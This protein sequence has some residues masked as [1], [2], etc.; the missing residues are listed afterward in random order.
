M[1]FQ[2]PHCANRLSIPDQY[3]G[4]LMKCPICSK[5][6]QAPNLVPNA[7]ASP[8]PP[9]APAPA[10]EGYK[11]APEPPKPAPPPPPP[12]PAATSPVSKSAAPPPPPPTGPTDYTGGF[13]GTLDPKI[14]PWIAPAC[15][16]LVLGLLFFPWVGQYWGSY[17]VNVQTGWGAAFGF[18]TPDETW[19]KIVN[20]DRE[21]DYAGVNVLVIFFIL[22]LLPAIL[23]AIVSAVLPLLHISLPPQVEQLKTW[24]WA[25]VAGVALLAFLLLSLQLVLHFSIENRILEQI[26]QKHKDDLAKQDV[27]LKQAQLRVATEFKAAGL[28]RTSYLRLT[29]YLCLLAVVAAGL[30][31]WLDRRGYAAPPPRIDVKW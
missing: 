24:R 1:D 3:A 2:C 4:T 21:K 16:I 8:P 6:F 19:E 29:W 25:A 30:Q 27:I 18:S 26:T 28:E 20:F 12:A 17:P 31:F 7:P 14:V 22:L 23:L 11:L 9:P 10:S 5:T 15:L 13:S